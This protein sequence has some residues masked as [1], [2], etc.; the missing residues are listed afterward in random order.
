MS[1][2]VGQDLDVPWTSYGRPLH[3]G[4]EL[5]ARSPAPAIQTQETSICAKIASALFVFKMCAKQS[6]NDYPI[7]LSIH[8]CENT[9]KM[10]KTT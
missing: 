9:K 2:T 4:L 7:F 10:L 1:W 5:F 6:E 3:N 8:C